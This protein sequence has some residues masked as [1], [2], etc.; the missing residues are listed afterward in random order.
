MK[1]ALSTAGIAIVV[2]IA[3][4]SP[5][6]AN[7]KLGPQRICAAKAEVVRLAPVAVTISAMRYAAIRKELA[8]A[9]EQ[10]STTARTRPG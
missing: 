1:S 5:A 3:F 2:A 8:S 6:S 7:V 4:A 10:S 9:T